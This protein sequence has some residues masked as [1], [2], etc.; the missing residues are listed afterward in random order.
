MKYLLFALIL[1]FS[2][3]CHGQARIQV[4]TGNDLK[5][6]CSAFHIDSPTLLQASHAG[7]C[8]GYIQGVQD[9]EKY[10]NA[11]HLEASALSFCISQDVEYGQVLDVVEKYLKDNPA[12]LHHDAFL[13]VHH[14]LHDAFPCKRS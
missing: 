10:R 2:A 6:F 11:A 14:A 13:L 1:T 7:Q 8:I 5:E 12:L 4:G 9:S 3:A